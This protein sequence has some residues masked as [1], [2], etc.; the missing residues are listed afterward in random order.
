MGS[1]IWS[2]YSL[3]FSQRHRSSGVTY[4]STGWK[5]A[6]R[7]QGIM[8]P[9]SPEKLNAFSVETSL[10]VSAATCHAGKGPQ[11]VGKLL[12]QAQPSCAVSMVAWR[13]NQRWL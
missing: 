5:I 11:T 13:Q 4:R 12:A 7:V 3:P 2:Q 8:F 10:P 6:D 1:D 9:S